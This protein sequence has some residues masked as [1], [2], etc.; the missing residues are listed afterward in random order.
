[1]TDQID[2]KISNSEY[3]DSSQNHL[4]IQILKKK[5]LYQEK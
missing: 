5:V 2:S 4:K 1:M 3:E